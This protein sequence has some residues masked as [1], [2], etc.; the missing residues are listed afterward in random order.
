MIVDMIGCDSGKE[1]DRICEETEK[2]I[3]MMN[4]GPKARK[5]EN[6]FEMILA[7]I[8][9]EQ[10]IDNLKK[11]VFISGFL[12]LDNQVQKG[13]GNQARII[14]EKMKVVNE[15]IKDCSETVSYQ[16]KALDRI[17]T[18]I[19]ISKECSNQ[20]F[21]EIETFDSSQ[22]KSKR[23]CLKFLLISSSILILIV[24]F[25]FVVSANLKH[26]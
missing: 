6:E 11:K 23:R 25:I 21:F 20:A 24:L 7:R 14:N 12:D 13:M 18:S 3:A 9:K 17:D 4:K 26:V 22:S 2:L 19:E 16:G 5:L 1:T 8:E 15:M 10:D